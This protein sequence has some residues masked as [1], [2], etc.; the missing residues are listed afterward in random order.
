MLNWEPSL[1]QMNTNLGTKF[2][3]GEHW[4][5][6]QVW[7]RWTLT[8]EPSVTAVECRSNSSQTGRV[9]WVGNL[10]LHFYDKNNQVYQVSDSFSFTS[11]CSIQFLNFHQTLEG[12]W[13]CFFC[14]WRSSFNHLPSKS[15]NLQSRYHSLLDL[16]LSHAYTCDILQENQQHKVP[17]DPCN[18]TWAEL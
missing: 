4:P 8:W 10:L 16:T 6:N 17:M 12:F 14:F 18:F 2:D 7:H 5:G 9:H 1:T 3:S 13:L 15:V 11:V